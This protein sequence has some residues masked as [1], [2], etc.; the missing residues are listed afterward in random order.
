MNDRKQQK[1][2]F[3]MKAM[4]QIFIE[5]L[6]KSLKINIKTFSN[7]LIYWIHFIMKKITNRKYFKETHTIQSESFIPTKSSISRFDFV[8]IKNSTS[9]SKRFDPLLLYRSS[10]IILRYS[11]TILQSLE[12][13]YILISSVPSFWSIFFF[14]LL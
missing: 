11:L 10:W 14:M 12:Y 1:S 9:K 4:L 3:Q 7:F 6:K 8:F 2:N 5:L 13:K